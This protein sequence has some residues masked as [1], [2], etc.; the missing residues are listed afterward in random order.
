M[1]IGRFRSAASI[2]RHQ[3][4]REGVEALHV[5]GAAPVGPAVGDAQA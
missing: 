4:Q 3:G 2:V 1:W 5:D